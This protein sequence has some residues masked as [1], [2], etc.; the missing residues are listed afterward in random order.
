MR[1]IRAGDTLIAYKLDRIARSLPH[2]FE[3]MDHLD[4]NGIGFRS[5]TKDINTC[6]TA[7]K[8]DPVSGVLGV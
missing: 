1:N 4:S 3:I 2:L 7:C 5:I 8:I 6:R